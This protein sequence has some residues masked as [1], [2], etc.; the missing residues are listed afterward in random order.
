MERNVV[1]EAFPGC[2]NKVAVPQCW[3]WHLSGLKLR[4]YICK[5]VQGLGFHVRGEAGG[6]GRAGRSGAERG[7]A[8]R[9]RAA[10]NG[11][12]YLH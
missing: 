10:W 4:L 2:E 5:R 8:G 3:I 1:L 6:A 9:G 12:T 7:E 11:S